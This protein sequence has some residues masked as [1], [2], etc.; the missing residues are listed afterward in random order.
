MHVNENRMCSSTVFKKITI[1]KNKLWAKIDDEWIFHGPSVNQLKMKTNRIDS[2]NA[3]RLNAIT[4][5][6]YRQIEVFC[7]EINECVQ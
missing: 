2:P 4:I 6:N 1:K 5:D 3:K 7:I